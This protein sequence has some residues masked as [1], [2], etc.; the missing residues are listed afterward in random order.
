MRYCVEPKGSA[1]G[2]GLDFFDTIGQIEKR[3]CYEI[4][5]AVASGNSGK[6]VPELSR[7][8]SAVALDNI[9][10][11]A[12]LRKVRSIHLHADRL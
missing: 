3:Y 11:R 7:S 6:T 5:N 2:W 4:F 9:G 12:H 8:L 10:I 1:D